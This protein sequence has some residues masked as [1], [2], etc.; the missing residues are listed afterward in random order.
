[1]NTIYIGLREEE[2][3]PKNGPSGTYLLP[4]IHTLCQLKKDPLKC[5]NINTTDLLLNS[6]GPKEVKERK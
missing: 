3:G 2:T 5:F 4:H 6:S 1:M